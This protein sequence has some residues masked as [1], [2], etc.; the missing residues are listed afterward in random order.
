MRVER[1]MIMMTVN[2]YTRHSQDSL[3]RGEKQVQKPNSCQPVHCGPQP[4]P[5]QV[6]KPTEFNLT[7]PMSFKMQLLG[8][9]WEI[10]KGKTLKI[11]LTWLC[12]SQ[13]WRWGPGFWLK[14]SW[15]QR[16]APQKSQHL[17]LRREKQ[18]KIISLRLKGRE[19]PNSRMKTRLKWTDHSLLCN[20]C[21]GTRSRTRL[22]PACRGWWRRQSRTESSTD[23]SSSRRTRR[24][25]QPRT[26]RTQCTWSWRTG[27]E[28]EEVLSLN[29]CLQRLCFDFSRPI[30]SLLKLWTMGVYS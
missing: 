15:V 18:I 5:A 28:E 30:F 14:I 21:S 9:F 22:S 19:N 8:T 1:K 7:T 6:R 3:H 16:A 23:L 4:G 13:D 2:T 12:H 17:E 10:L 25:R 24:A 29:S 27:T 11:K 26:G 20:G